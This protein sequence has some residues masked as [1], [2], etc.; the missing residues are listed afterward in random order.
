[1]I[2][3]QGKVLAQ[4]LMQMLVI[5]LKCETSPINTLNLFKPAALKTLIVNET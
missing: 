2:V 3:T 1:V 5:E 4:I